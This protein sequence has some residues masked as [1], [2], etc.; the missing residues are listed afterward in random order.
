MLAL[1]GV[2]PKPAACGCGCVGALKSRMYHAGNSVVL[3]SPGWVGALSPAIIFTSVKTTVKTKKP[4]SGLGGSVALIEPA[5][6]EDCDTLR[7]VT[8]RNRTAGLTDRTGEDSLIAEAAHVSMKNGA[9]GCNGHCA[10]FTDCS[11]ALTRNCKSETSLLV[12][13]VSLEGVWN[14]PMKVLRG[15]A[16]HMGAANTRR[17]TSRPGM[18]LPER[19]NNKNLVQIH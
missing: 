19:E 8:T 4:A 2:S 1:G 15:S 5:G 3:S 16:T 10:S 13:A 7:L 9:A 11:N 12:E 14:S 6:I 17:V 18:F